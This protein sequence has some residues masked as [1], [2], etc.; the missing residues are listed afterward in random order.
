[1]R[2][3]RAIFCAILKMRS[4]LN[5]SEFVVV[6]AKGR[7]AAEEEVVERERKCGEEDQTGEETEEEV[8]AETGSAAAAGGAE[9]LESSIDFSFDELEASCLSQYRPT[10]QLAGAGKGEIGQKPLKLAHRNQRKMKAAYLSFAKNA[11]AL[12]KSKT[13]TQLT[14]T[15]QWAISYNLTD[16]SHHSSSHDSFI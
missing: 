16:S 15:G 4:L 10:D 6:E 1:M 11:N 2:K 8:A 12:F 13:F 9:F 14:R 5:A 7:K 3:I